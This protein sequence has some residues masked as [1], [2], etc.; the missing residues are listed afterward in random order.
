MKFEEIRFDFVHFFTING[1]RGEAVLFSV[2]AQ[3][4]KV[5]VANMHA[6]VLM[7]T[8]SRESTRGR[9]DMTYRW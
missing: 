9:E 8:I 3:L 4:H 6:D 2:T 5:R 7:S 1:Q